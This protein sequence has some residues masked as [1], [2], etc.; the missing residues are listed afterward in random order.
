M[1]TV[2]WSCRLAMR[3]VAIHKEQP[4]WQKLRKERRMLN[5]VLECPNCLRNFAAFHKM[6]DPIVS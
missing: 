3:D 2:I 1:R 4:R 6:T 5:R